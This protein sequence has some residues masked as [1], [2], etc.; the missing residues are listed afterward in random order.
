MRRIA[1]RMEEGRFPL[2]IAE[3]RGADG[4]RLSE[5]RRDAVIAQL[6]K[7]GVKDAAERTQVGPIVGE[8]Y[9]HVLQFVRVL[10]F[11]PL[12][13]FL[14]LQAFVFLTRPATK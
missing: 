10:A 12:G 8:W 1:S 2:L 5:R 7:E 14:I 9:P 6:K 4:R 13:L 3:I 11:L